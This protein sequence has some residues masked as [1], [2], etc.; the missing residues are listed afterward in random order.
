MNTKDSPLTPYDRPF[1]VAFLAGRSCPISD[2]PTTELLE[3]PAD[4]I[5]HLRIPEYIDDVGDAGTHER[6]TRRISAPS[7]AEINRPAKRKG[8]QSEPPKRGSM[9]QARLAFRDVRS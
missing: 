6:A 5:A 3:T 4:A 9:L 2:F 7:D 8:A 1:V